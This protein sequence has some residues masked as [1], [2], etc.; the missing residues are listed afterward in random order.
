MTEEKKVAEVVKPDDYLTITLGKESKELY[1]SAGLMSLIAGM[2]GEFED[3]SVIYLD[4]VLRERVL[5]EVLVERDPRGVPV[6]PT[7]ALTLMAFDLST[8]EGEKIARW[9]GEHTVN[10]FM[11][12]ARNLQESVGKQEQVFLNLAESLAGMNNLLQEKP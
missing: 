6:E 11:T 1:M 9:V 12:S 2:I 10:F 4:P 8:S 7:G 3:F 5:I